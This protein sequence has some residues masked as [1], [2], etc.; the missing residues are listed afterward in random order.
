ME[1]KAEKMFKDLGKKID[2]FMLELDDAGDNLKDELG[3]RLEELKKSK[4]SL[5]NEYKSFKEKN[6]D[7]WAE[8]ENSLEKAGQELKEA[9]KAAFSKPPKDSEEKK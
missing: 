1:G 7:K 5:G 9:F 4:D 3:S 2:S 6:K 8:V